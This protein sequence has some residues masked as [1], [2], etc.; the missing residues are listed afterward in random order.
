MTKIQMTETKS[1]EHLEI[2]ITDLFRISVFEFR[3]YLMG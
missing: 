1:F 3:T 2:R